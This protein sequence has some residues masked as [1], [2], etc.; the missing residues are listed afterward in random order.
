METEQIAEAIAAF[1]TDL[2]NSAD[3]GSRRDAVWWLGRKIGNEA[4]WKVAEVFG[5]FGSYY[6]S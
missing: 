2:Q 6:R 5:L 3:M 4:A 1:A